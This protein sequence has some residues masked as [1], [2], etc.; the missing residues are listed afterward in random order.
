MKKI[1]K[2][3]AIILCCVACMPLLVACNGK[4]GTELQSVLFTQDVFEADEGQE[5]K[6]SYKTYPSTATNYNIRFQVD[7]DKCKLDTKTAT[8]M[9]RTGSPDVA[10]V[11]IVYGGGENDF[12]TCKVIKK[13]YPT[14]ISFEKDSTYI[15]KNSSKLLKLKATMLDGTEKIIDQ[16]SYNIELTSSAPNIVA[17]NNE[18]MMATSTGVSGSATITAKIVRLSG[19]YASNSNYPNGYEAKITINVIDNISTANVWLSDRSEYFVA[20]RNRE[21][22]EQNTFITEQNYLGLSFKFFSD[23]NLWVDSSLVATNVISSD[24]SIV[25][26]QNNNGKYSLKFN[27]SGTACITIVTDASDKDGNPVQF[28]FYIINITPDTNE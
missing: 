7:I 11:T 3:L 5:I 25:E 12:T 1:T 19:G 24:S 9:F 18:N 23:S 13:K 22:T 17:V 15:T 27:G 6:L 21:Q 20:S 26:V 28:L 10:N 8:F 4:V 16:N 14:E 2:I